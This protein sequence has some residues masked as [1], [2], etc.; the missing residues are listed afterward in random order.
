M[1]RTSPTVTTRQSP[2]GPIEEGGRHSKPLILGTKQTMKVGVHRG[3]GW[4][5]KHT[6]ILTS[7]RGYV[8]RLVR[9]RLSYPIFPIPCL[10]SNCLHL[11]SSGGLFES[12]PC[13]RTD[14]QGFKEFSLSD[15]QPVTPVT[16]DDSNNTNRHPTSIYKH[17]SRTKIQSHTKTVVIFQDS[18]S[19]AS[20]E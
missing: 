12:C 6:Q 8:P 5:V 15:L 7:S 3:F 9:L 4:S 2:R 11:S 19:Y 10:Y 13:Q 18:I 16:N 17:L 1:S 20:P 14:Y